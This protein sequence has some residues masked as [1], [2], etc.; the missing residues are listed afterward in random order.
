LWKET[1]AG[2]AGEKEEIRRNPRLAS[3]DEEREGKRGRRN[4]KREKEEE[5]EKAWAWITTRFSR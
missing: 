1:P 2:S 3:S 4:Q 5:E